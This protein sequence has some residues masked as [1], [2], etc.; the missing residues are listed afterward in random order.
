MTLAVIESVS[1]DKIAS[2]HKLD[3]AVKIIYDVL[4]TIAIKLGPN[5]S[6]QHLCSIL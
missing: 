4:L 2:S 6:C 1:L 3:N 5:N